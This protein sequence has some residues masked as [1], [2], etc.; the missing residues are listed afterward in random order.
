MDVFEAITHRRSPSQFLDRPIPQDILEKILEAATWAPSAQNMQN[1][2]FIVLGGGAKQDFL[3][4]LQ[5]RFA[6]ILFALQSSGPWTAAQRTNWFLK[7]AAKAPILVAVF[8][9][10]P[11]HLVPDAPLSVAAAVQ[12]LLLAARA[13]GIGGRW[14]TSGLE[15][16]QDMIYDY[17]DLEE[18]ELVGLIVLGYPADVPPPSPRRS[19]RIDWRLE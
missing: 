17:Y 4:E 1:W 3:A 8:S 12:N 10:V 5:V 19:G 16:V 18:K 11:S 7:A 13:E 2:Y 15:T 6:D 14:Y 9:D